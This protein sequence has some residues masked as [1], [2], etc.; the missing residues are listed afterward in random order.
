MLTK[1]FWT[2]GFGIH[3]GL[4]LMIAIS[5]Y[6]GILPTT[7]GKIPH[8]DLLGHAVLIGFLA[9]FL[10]GILDFRPL[11][12]GKFSSIRLAPILIM[13][14]AAVEEVAQ[15]LSPRRSASL[16]DFIADVVGIVLCSWLARHLT[17]RF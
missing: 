2:Y 16:G 4:V 7:Y 10:D 5:A 8:V 6:L 12:S 3:L 15:V 13:G 11:F 17:E 1:T 9:F 14:I